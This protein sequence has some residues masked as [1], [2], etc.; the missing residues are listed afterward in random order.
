VWA[1]TGRYCRSSPRYTRRWSRR[2][3]YT[4]L[5]SGR[6]RDHRNRP[7]AAD[8]R[9]RAQ[10]A[11]GTLVVSRL[12]VG[13]RFFRAIN[14]LLVVSFPAW[15]PRAR[16]LSASGHA[17]NYLSSSDP[18]PRSR[19]GL[20]RFQY[21]L[22]RRQRSRSGCGRFH[23]RSSRRSRLAALWL[24]GGFAPDTRVLGGL[25]RSAS[26][27]FR[28]SALRWVTKKCS[29]ILIAGCLKRLRGEAREGRSF[30]LAQDRLGGG[31][32]FSYV[33]AKSDERKRSH[34]SLFQQPVT[35]WNPDNR[36]S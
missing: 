12:R 4:V 34:M 2:I 15:N 24:R 26:V 29:K 30:D 25:A 17:P 31:V 28:E 35:R 14:E 21:V 36:Q 19:S 32:L 1:I 8:R 13:H 16:Q 7:A 5:G 10:G 18:R 6:R 11:V 27:W 23:G 20:R 3:R 33:D 22:A 9:C